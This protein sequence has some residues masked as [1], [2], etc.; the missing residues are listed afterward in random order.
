M[1]ASSLSLSSL[2][3]FIIELDTVLSQQ[4]VTVLLQYLLS[5]VCPFFCLRFFTSLSKLF[6]NNTIGF[7]LFTWIILR[8]VRS[9]KVTRGCYTWFLFCCITRYSLVVMNYILRKLTRI[10]IGEDFRYFKTLNKITS[11][12]ALL[13]SLQVVN[14]LG[15]MIQQSF[16]CSYRTA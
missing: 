4:W 11:E 14:D 9:N 3:L 6:S 8:H 13:E 1:L 2:S 5:F 10:H 12:P 16:P 7:C 15:K